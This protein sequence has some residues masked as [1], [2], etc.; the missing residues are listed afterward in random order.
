MISRD[1]EIDGRTPSPSRSAWSSQYLSTAAQ[2]RM[3]PQ[4][5]PILTDTSPLGIIFRLYLQPS[6]SIGAAF[7]EV[8]YDQVIKFTPVVSP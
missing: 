1:C 5:K 3:G 4:G 8:V 2:R 7:S 6:T